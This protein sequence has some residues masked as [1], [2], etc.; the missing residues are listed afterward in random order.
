[1]I[2]V[3]RAVIGFGL[4]LV[5]T[6]TSQPCGYQRLRREGGRGEWMDGILHMAE[7]ITNGKQNHRT[8]RTPR[9]PGHTAEPWG[10]LAVAWAA[11][12]PN[13]LNRTYLPVS[14]AHNL[15]HHPPT[16]IHRPPPHHVTLS[17]RTDSTNHKTD[18]FHLLP[19][20]STVARWDC[21]IRIPWHGH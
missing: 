4:L 2:Y 19:C 14:P 9:T 20:H 1:M 18:T 13:K 7:H 8:N 3:R 10:S 12:I 5:D 11:G 17:Q 15:H 16:I 6:R 21:G